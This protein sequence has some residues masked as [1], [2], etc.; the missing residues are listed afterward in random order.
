MTKRIQVLIEEQEYLEIQESARRR[1]MTV[2]EWIRRRCAKQ[3]TT[4]QG[5][6]KPSCDA[7]ADASRHSFPTADIEA[8]L[9]EIEACPGIE[10][11]G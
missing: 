9:G 1:R 7:I 8:M 6:P 11:L 5:P 3:W 2:S 10:R 4:S